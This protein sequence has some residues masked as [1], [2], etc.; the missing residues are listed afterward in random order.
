MQY[1]TRQVCAPLSGGPVPPESHEPVTFLMASK[2]WRWQAGTVS[3]HEGEFSC[4]VMS[5]AAQSLVGDVVD[6]QWRVNHVTGQW[7]G[8]RAVVL[9]ASARKR[10]EVSFRQAMNVI[11]QVERSSDWG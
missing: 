8:C 5:V 4:P 2:A 9:F 7:E 6:M 10:K 3:G 1:A 11:V